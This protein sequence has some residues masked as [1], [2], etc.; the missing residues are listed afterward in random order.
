[1]TFFDALGPSIPVL[2]MFLGVLLVSTAMAVV[3]LLADS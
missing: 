1:M 2:L 3:A